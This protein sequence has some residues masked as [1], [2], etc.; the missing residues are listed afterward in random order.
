MKTSKVIII[1]DHPIVRAGLAAVIAQDPAM[2]VCA[3]CSNADESIAAVRQHQPDLAIVD[4]TLGTAS[5]MPLFQCLQRHQ[6]ALRML[7][8]SMHDES[9]FAARALKA[10]AH[11]YLMKG[12]AID[13]L[14]EAMHV[15]LSGQLYVS[16]RMRSLMLHDMVQGT[17]TGNQNSL[18]QL[19]ATEMVVLQM[20]G[21]GA[22]TREIADQLKR[23]LKT[24]ETHRSNIRNKLELANSAA[25]VHFAIQ[26]VQQ[27]DQSG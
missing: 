18:R 5:A 19:T 26:W 10:G 8:L 12:S 13:T 24:I 3:D 25:L 15:V 4:M 21:A 2:V 16:D 14:R 9:V 17:P 6:P 7:A 23:S 11:G 1:D 20:I 27:D 22:G